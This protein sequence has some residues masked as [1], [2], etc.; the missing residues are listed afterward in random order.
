MVAS[1]LNVSIP[2]P[3]KAYVEAQVDSGDYGTPSEYVRDLILDDR[4]RRLTRLEDR[5]L[6]NLKSKPIDF[7][8]EELA[9]GN[10][11]NLCRSKLRQSR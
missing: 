2:E 1:S 3:L 5:L 9:Q 7:S 10:F 6:E 11:V 4:D 8:D